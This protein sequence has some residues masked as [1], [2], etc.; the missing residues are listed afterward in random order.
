[1]I[2]YPNS[3]IN[4]GLNIVEKRNDGFHNIETVFYP[5]NICDAL[6]FI[7]TEGE[8]IFTTTGLKIEGNQSDNLV[9]KAY[10]LLAAE[11][12]L[13][14]IN[15]HLHKKVPMGAGLGGGSA[16][17]SYM[18]QLINYYF[19]LNIG[20]EKLA[21]YA[22]QLGSDCAFFIYNKPMYGCGKGNILSDIDLNLNGYHIILI[23]S[24]IHVSTAEAYS[25]CTPHRWD[26]PLKDV[27]TRPITEW[28]ETLK[29][30]F[31]QSVFAIHPELKTIKETLYDFGA[32]YAA[33]SGSG[34]TIFGIFKAPQ[35]T[36]SLK[37]K[38]KK[39]FPDNDI[40]IHKAEL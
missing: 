34:S 40:T 36:N 29:N 3:K 7:E 9:L 4:L 35:E 27:I 31:E 18:L 32:I 28:K 33:M 25:R 37:T 26:I 15:I 13:P 8:T 16:D 1:M 22:S 38:L 19:E 14:P 6:E 23:S 10:R 5:I 24:N 17:A 20:K 30:D 2:T 39:L 12:N 21:D 11:Y